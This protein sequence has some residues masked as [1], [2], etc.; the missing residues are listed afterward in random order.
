MKVLYMFR[1]N[2][3]QVV[4]SL[5]NKIGVKGGNNA[6]EEMKN[7]Q[8]IIISETNKQT[9]IILPPFPPLSHTRPD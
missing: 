6:R 4:D 3:E 8:T 1:V 2:W 7:K 5:D 9:K